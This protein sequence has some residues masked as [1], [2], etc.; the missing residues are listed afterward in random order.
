MIDGC[1]RLVPQGRFRL[2]TPGPHSI[3]SPVDENR[4]AITLASVDFLLSQRARDALAGLSQAHLEPSTILPIATDLRRTF[5]AAEAGALLALAQL[6]QAARDEFPAAEG[7]YFTAEALEQATAW[8]V[9]AH[10]AAWFDQ[11]APPGPVLDLGCGIGGDTLALAARR[12]VIAFEKDPLRLRLAQANAE[13]L[14]LARRIEFHL[15]D[16][17]AELAAG[18]LPPAAAAFADPSRRV[19]GRRVFS[20]HGMAPPLAA[21]LALQQAVPALGAKVM[22]G[23]ADDELPDRCGVEFISHAGVCKEAVL[24]FGPLAQQR[25]WASVH[26]RDGWQRIVA[27]GAPP[28]VGPLQAGM[29]LHEP[30]PAVIRAGAFHELCDPLDA[31]LFDPQIAYLVAHGSRLHPLVQSFRLDEVHPFNLKL[32]NRRLQALEVG[33]VELKKRGAPMEPEHLRPRLKLVAGGRPAVVFF[34]R[35]GDDHLM[36]IGERLAQETQERTDA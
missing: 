11:H 2:A 25:R 33:V 12:P 10:R 14:G 26:G 4:P 9:A 34:T 24:W 19:A 13:A 15:A 7:L 35:R 16:W 18:R 23:V 3:I 8:P 29:L 20:L 5:T 17:T 31:H 22:P 32:L 30:D 6:R 27:G 36:L 1:A 21:L 28:P